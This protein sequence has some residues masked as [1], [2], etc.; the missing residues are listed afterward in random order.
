MEFEGV[1]PSPLKLTYSAKINGFVM[2]EDVIDRAPMTGRLSIT[3]I[4]PI[5]ELDV[6]CTDS[7][8]DR[9]II[10]FKAQLIKAQK[11]VSVLIGK[12][13]FVKGTLH[14]RATKIGEVYLHVDWNL[15]LDLL[16]SLDQ[17]R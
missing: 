7:Q 2:V 14:K 1:W 4:P 11:I 12:P 8:G 5:F 9:Y 17:P 10:Y 3:P 16:P 15:M 6:K 13:T